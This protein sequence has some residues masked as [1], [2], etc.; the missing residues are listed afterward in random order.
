MNESG[1][2]CGTVLGWGPPPEEPTLFVPAN[3]AVA[4]VVSIVVP[5][6][7]EEITVGLFVAWCHEGLRAA[8]VDGEII[9][10]DSSTDATPQ[11]ALEAGA[12]VLRVPLRGLGRAYRDAVPFARGRYLILGDA[13]CT[14]DFRAIKPFIE[15][16]DDGAE[17]VMGSRFRG[18]IEDGAM[19]LHHRYFGTPVTTFLMNRLFGTRHS[20]IHCGMR[21]LTVDAFDR[22]NM[23]ADGWEYASE[24]LVAASRLGLRTAEVP[25]HFHRDR[26]GRESH[27][28]R[29][30]WTTPFRAGWS[31]LRVLFT[32]AADVFLIGVGAP[33]ALV[34]TVA[35]AALSFGPVSL[36]A[37]TL[38]LHT[39]ALALALALMGWFAVGLGVVARM[40]Y[41]RGGPYSLR[42]ADRLRFTRAMIVSATLVVAGVVLDV[43]FLWQ[44]IANDLEVAPS[45]GLSSHMALTGLFLMGL[46][47][48]LF[49]TML[50][51]HAV[52][53]QSQRMEAPSVTRR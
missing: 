17:F 20:D 46:G 49:T 42:W 21:A 41:D 36:G 10:V 6:L 4:P 35:L 13:D 11:I 19:P 43:S 29:Q 30:G 7:D 52:A 8:G 26:A 40:I 47:F 12:R 3:D 44:Y 23:R 14:Y 38:T 53:M 15:A 37:I 1:G 39:A 16:L 18:S 33:L 9:I 22:M 2:G 45:G 51:V 48:I 25:I 27:V 32:N 31:T 28:K 24:M 5:A 50:V 34:G